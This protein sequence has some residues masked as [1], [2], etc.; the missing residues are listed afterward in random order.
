MATNNSVLFVCLG[1]ICR[2]PLADG[3]MI[4]EVNKRG[5]AAQF[6]IDSA[7]TYAGHAGEKADKRMRKTAANH[8]VELK[9]IARQFI[10]DDFD[11]F[12]HI[13]VMDDSNLNNVLNLTRN[14]S[15]RNKVIKLRSFDN[16]KSGKDV[17]DPYYGGIA[18]F[19]NCYNVVSESIVN[20]LNKLLEQD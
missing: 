11:K 1:N 4:H 17:D 8:G 14:D 2:S 5:I 7:G 9:S 10:V 12:E 3:L 20:F 19:D 13:V 15:D 16:Q 18:G 6:K